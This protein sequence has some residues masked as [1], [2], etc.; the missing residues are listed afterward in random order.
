MRTEDQA[1]IDSR[2]TGERNEEERFKSAEAKLTGVCDAGGQMRTLEV[3][4]Y[5]YGVQTKKFVF[6]EDY[7][8][9]REV[10]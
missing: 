1:R 2:N 6:I 3:W 8:E 7:R 5:L 4:E 10:Q 9:Y